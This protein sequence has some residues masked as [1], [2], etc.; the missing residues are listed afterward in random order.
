MSRELPNAGPK[1]WPMVRLNMASDE[2]TPNSSCRTAFC[3][4]FVAALV[5]ATTWGIVLVETDHY[6]AAIAFATEA[7]WWFCAAL[8]CAVLGML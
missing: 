4:A 2:T 8:V 5:C 3:I 1:T 6:D 7:T